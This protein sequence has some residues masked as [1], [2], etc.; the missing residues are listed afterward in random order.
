MA[1]AGERFF[2]LADVF[3]AG[4]IGYLSGSV[5][6]GLLLTRYA[7]L[8]DVRAIGSGNIG[9]TNVLRTGRRGLAAAT[10]VLDILKGLVPVLVVSYFFGAI[11]A[12]LVAGAMALVGHMFPVWLKF[13]GGKG[14]A[15]YIGVAF[16]MLWP[17]GLGFA[18]VWLVTA[19]TLRYS[20]LSALAASLAAPVAAFVVGG[21]VYGI[22]FFLM[23]VLVIVRHRSNIERLIRGEEDKIGQSQTS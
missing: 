1:P 4:V 2:M 8:G 17:V 19:F 18:L 13:K 21:D 22:V 9:A 16:G 10:L 3:I 14:V 11:P 20:S 12:A 23:S 6:Y 7:G 5:P 15:T